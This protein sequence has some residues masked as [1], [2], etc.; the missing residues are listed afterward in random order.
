MNALPVLYSFRRC[1]YAIRARL[2]ISASQT[3]VQLREVVLKDKP[4]AMLEASPK[5]TVPVLVLTK[6]Q[7]IAESLDIMHWALNQHD[8]DNWLASDNPEQQQLIAAL[9]A[10]ND[11]VFKPNLDKYKY[12]DRFPEQTQ[13]AYRHQCESTLQ[14]L[15]HCLQR[16]KFLT[17]DRCTLA[18]AAI[19]PFI[20]QFAFVDKVWFDQSPYPA[21]QAW[22]D[23]WLNSS[24]FLAVMHKYPQ[25][26]TD[27]L[28]TTFPY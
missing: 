4:A 16:T 27:Q 11:R 21:L 2:G 3:Q 24:Q 17:A 14:Q 12:F 15:E 7:V 28:V 19:F 10:D 9:I 6:E 8:P 5:G 18:D 20:R 26:Q 22:L 23:N 25:W 1:P 13:A